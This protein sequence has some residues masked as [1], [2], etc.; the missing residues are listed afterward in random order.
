MVIG[1]SQERFQRPGP[2]NIIIGHS[3]LDKTVIEAGECS[4][5]MTQEEKMKHNLVNTQHSLCQ[6]KFSLSIFYELLLFNVF[7]F[8]SFLFRLCSIFTKTRTDISIC[9]PYIHFL[10]SLSLTEL[11]LHSRWQ[12]KVLKYFFPTILQISP[13]HKMEF[14]AEECKQKQF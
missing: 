5:L 4:L 7:F 6:R 2:A 14:I 9:P 3:Q 13:G 10:H 11:Q 12:C 1:E 8:F